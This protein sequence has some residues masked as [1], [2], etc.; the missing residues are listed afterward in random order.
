MEEPAMTNQNKSSGLRLV[1][2]WTVV[3]GPLVWGILTTA[4][5]LKALFG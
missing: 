1:V 3:G 2:Y 5:K 4:L